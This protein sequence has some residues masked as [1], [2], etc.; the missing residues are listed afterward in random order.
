MLRFKSDVNGCSMC[1]VGDD[2]DDGDGD[3][4]IY[5]YDMHF[6]ISTEAEAA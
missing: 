3:I 4:Y 6:F 1:C 2:S 5:T